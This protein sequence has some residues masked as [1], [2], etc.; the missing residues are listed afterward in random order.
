M[1][2]VKN[3][4]KSN[5]KKVILVIIII[6]I[7]IYVFPKLRKKYKDSQVML[8]IS[9]LNT[10]VPSA[11]PGCDI[12]YPLDGFN[13][14]VCFYIYIDN[15]YENYSYWRHLFHKGTPPSKTESINFEYE[16]MIFD[17]WCDLV[18]I[19]TD[20]SPGVWLHPNLNNLRFA[21]NTDKE[22]ENITYNKDA[23]HDNINTD[24]TKAVIYNDCTNI[25]YCD[26]ENISIDTPT[27][28]TFV[29]NGKNIYVYKNAILQKVCA[30]MGRPKF[31]N[32]AMYFN[33]QRS[34]NGYLKKFKYIPYKIDEKEVKRIYNQRF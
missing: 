31:N 29:V 15:Y 28:I 26:I 11:L 32:G 14:S 23:I 1:D 17:G 7:T 10:K 22:D 30:L 8:T 16:N 24:Q 33:Y 2:K 3:F 19:F 12:V 34:T 25:E 6:S 27:H 20:Q 5:Y 9:R 13:Y 21:L 18:N 4:L